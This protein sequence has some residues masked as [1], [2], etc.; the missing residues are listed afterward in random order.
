MLFFHMIIM[1]EYKVGMGYLWGEGRRIWGQGEGGVSLCD[2][3][4]VIFTYTL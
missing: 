4:T 2:N 3:I 1:Y